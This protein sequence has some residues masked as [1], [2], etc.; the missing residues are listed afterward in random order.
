M[1]C[2][3]CEQLFD[4]Y[5]DGQLAGTLRLEFD[6]HRLRCPRCQQVL[7]MLESVSHVL[8]SDNAPPRASEGFTERV[9][10]QVQPAPPRRLRLFRPFLRPRVLVG[11]AAFQAAA[12]VLIALTWHWS[13]RPVAPVAPP[14]P[15]VVAEDIE[16]RRTEL[17]NIIASG[18][19][20][21]LY[22]MQAAGR[23]LT[24]DLSQLARYLD[25]PMPP[26]VAGE[27]ARFARENAW[28]ALWNSMLPAA[29]PESTEETATTGELHSL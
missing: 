17:R 6:A 5:L 3:E 7:A 22:E 27:T 18:V 25:I 28:Q 4:A 10:A 14:A 11:A 19:E 26:D 23:R 12:V 13:A 29:T 9:M 8:S 2:A 16:S 24:D 1:T 15:A 20:D 21:R